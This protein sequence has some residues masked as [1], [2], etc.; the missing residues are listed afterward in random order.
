MK[1]KAR[2]TNKETYYVIFSL[3]V[4]LLF[5][6]IFPV[7][8]IRL[9]RLLSDRIGHYAMNT[10]LLC[11]LLQ[12]QYKGKGRFIFYTL[13]GPICNQQLHRMHKRK[14]N[15]ISLFP[16]M[17][18]QVDRI[19]TL[20]LRGRYETDFKIRM[21]SREGYQDIHGFLASIPEPQL[22]FTSEEVEKGQELLKQAGLPLDARYVCLLVRDA[23][24]LS[25]AYL[26]TD[27]S[28]HNFRDADVNTYKKAALFLA[29]K[30]YY[31][32]R[33]GQFVCDKF[34][35]SHPKVIDYAHHPMRSDF[36]DIY[37]SAH[38]QFFI[39]TSSG[40]DAVAQIFRRPVVLTNLAPLNDQLQYWY[41]CELFIPKKVKSE[42][43]GQWVCFSDI[44]RLFGHEGNVLP[45]LKECGMELIN[46]SEDEILAVVQEMESRVRGV[47]VETEEDRASFERVKTLAPLSMVADNAVILAKP[48]RF[49]TRLGT[50]FLQKNQAWM[51]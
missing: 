13:A 37:L 31:V 28:Y 35:L 43:T 4:A 34:N 8:Q 44:Y 50:D 47:W 7:I 10:E 25:R 30:G 48:E 29:E 23:R 46:N 38:C 16:P 12:A 11:C 3:P 22:T 2:I 1:V 42:N 41:P 51:K 9:I 17:W 18:K 5:L 45:R 24:Y 40:L 36:L 49:Y 27:W 33:M 14:I 26:T 19:L 6:M 20:V 39:S 15:V 32:F 21:E